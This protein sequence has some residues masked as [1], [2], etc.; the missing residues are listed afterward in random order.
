MK[1]TNKYNVDVTRAVIL[2]LE[3]KITSKEFQKLINKKEDKFKEFDKWFNKLA[4]KNGV[5][6]Y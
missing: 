6:K 4:K 2:L 3:N 5:T 1:V